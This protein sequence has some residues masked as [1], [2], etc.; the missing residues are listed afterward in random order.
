MGQKCSEIACMRV[1]VCVC[2]SKMS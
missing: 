2:R 1:Y